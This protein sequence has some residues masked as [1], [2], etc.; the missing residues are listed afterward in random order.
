MHVQQ[1][2]LTNVDLTAIL[3]GDVSGNWPDEPASKTLS[4]LEANTAIA[5]LEHVD[6]VA[7]APG[8]LGIMSRELNQPRIN[9]TLYKFAWRSV[10]GA[11]TGEKAFMLFTQNSAPGLVSVDAELEYPGVRTIQAGT[12][13]ESMFMAQGTPDSG[14]A[15]VGLAT[16]APVTGSGSLLTV[17]SDQAS[18]EFPTIVR[19]AINDGYNAIV[20]DQNGSWMEE[21]IDSDGHSFWREVV[22][23]T[24]PEDATSVFRIPP[25]QATDGNALE[26]TWSSVD[27]REYLVERMDQNK[28][29]HLMGPH[30]QMH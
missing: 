7:K 24:D 10:D 5:A 17:Y 13:T 25:F 21:D 9:N 15:H 8:L 2:H 3:I 22:A 19:L 6:M 16:S 29:L 4:L 28:L 1:S 12:L 26:L 11:N 18:M 20:W 23:G 14:Q 27:G 30:L